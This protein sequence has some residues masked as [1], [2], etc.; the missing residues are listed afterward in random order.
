VS[1][2]AGLDPRTPVLVGTGTASR[3]AEAAELAVDAARRAGDDAGGRNL[4]GRVGLVLVPQGIWGYEDLGRHVAAAV[5]APARGLRSVLAEVGILQQTVISRACEAIASGAADAVLVVGAEAKLRAS[6]AAREGVELGETAA[7]GPPDQVV[8]PAGDILARA[9]IERD[10]AVPAH[11]YA[12]IESAL[13]HA[14]GIDHEAQVRRLGELW[15]RFAMVARDRVESIDRSAPTAAEIATPRPDNRMLASPYTK[16]LC[17]Q[18]NVD[19][20]VALLFT[21]AALAED[22][23]VARERWVFPVAAA[24]S[25]HMVPL[26]A[27]VDL[28]RCRA[29]GALADAVREHH[30]LDVAAADAVDLYSCFPAAVQV[31]ARELGLALDRRLTVTGGM[32]FAGGP[33]NSYALH[34]TAA[35][36]DVLRQGAGPTTGLV[37]SV[38]AILT[39]VGLGLWSSE[40]PARPWASLDVTDAARAATPERPLQPDAT[41][42]SGRAL[43]AASTVVHERGAPD[44]VVAVVDL[45]DGPRTVAVAR[46]PALA[47]TVVDD[48]LCGR[49]VEV[50]E[51]GQLVM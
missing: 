19:Q 26:T 17:S 21:S 44:R 37:T 38:S 23:G 31:Q 18:W 40:P 32:T 36:A 43:I 50:P 6:R 3:D 45:P 13:R 20:A 34:A 30:G 10:L 47:A 1:S 49:A 51:P 33:L 2:T 15:A 46:D 29:V 41:D 11:Q 16:L 39:K 48:D 8:L 4:V 28:H 22:A 14:D 35:M 12:L 24:E 25:N 27:R 42:R 7:P 5:G 9:E